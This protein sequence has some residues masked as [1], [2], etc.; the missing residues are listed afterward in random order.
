MNEKKEVIKEVNK[1]INGYINY[2][3]KE[4]DFPEVITF[5]R[6]VKKDINKI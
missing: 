1:I 5:L 6:E 4:L 3:K 2:I